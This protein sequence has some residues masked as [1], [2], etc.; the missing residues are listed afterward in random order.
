MHR[1]IRKT[2]DFWGV[3][4]LALLASAALLCAPGCGS[5]DSAPKSAVTRA[6]K[7]RKAAES[8][9]LPGEQPLNEMVAAVT[10]AKGPPVEL[11]F[12]LPVRPEVGQVTE[13]DVA[14]V[15]SQPVPDSV[16]ISFQV[17]EGLEIVAGSQMD[18]VEKLTAGTPIRHVLKVLPKRDGIFTISAVVSF[19]AGNIESTRAFSIPVISGV[20]LPD[21]VAKGP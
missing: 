5:G 12:A 15:P 2:G 18:R 14:L 4:W 8:A 13:L 6:H 1:A 9:A 7:G 17:A 10:P 20:G 16:S 19:T 11:K 3:G 21:Q